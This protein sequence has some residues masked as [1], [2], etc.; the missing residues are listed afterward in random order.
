MIRI[1]IADDHAVVRQGLMQIVSDT[2]DIVVS[3]EASNGREVLAKISK[4]KYDVVVLDVG[5][6]D[7]SGLDMRS[8][9]VHFWDLKP[10]LMWRWFFRWLC[11]PL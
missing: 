1:L 3:D 6:P 8:P 5:M 9:A 2:S 11:F 10:Y 4:N 7:L